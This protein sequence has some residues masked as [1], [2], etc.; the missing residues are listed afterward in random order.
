M[1]DTTLDREHIWVQDFQGIAY[2][3][4]FAVIG[5]ICVKWAPQDE[6]AFFI[7]LLTVFSPFATVITTSITGF[8]RS[9]PSIKF[10]SFTFS[11]APQ[12]LAGGLRST[13]TL[14]SV[15]SVSSSGTSSIPMTH[16]PIKVSL[17]KNSQTFKKESLQPTSAKTESSHTEPWSP[18]PL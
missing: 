4:D 5:I 18:T 11:C 2:A 16:S 12:I 7:S 14:S 10:Q 17:H 8:V 13:C 9:H 6:A 3:A 15:P 1:R